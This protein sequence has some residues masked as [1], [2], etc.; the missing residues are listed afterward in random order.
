M[1]RAQFIL[2]SNTPDHI[3]IKDVGDHENV[4]T[5]TNDAEAVVDYYAARLR[6]RALEYIDSDGC[7]NTLKVKAGK[8]DGF[9]DGFAT[10]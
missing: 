3:R 9:E 5:I 4:P 7:R 1:P 10:S 8:F 6:G 2:L